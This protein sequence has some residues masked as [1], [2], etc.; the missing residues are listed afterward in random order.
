MGGIDEHFLGHG[1]VLSPAQHKSA[2]GEVE[3]DW[4]GLIEANDNPDDIARWPGN[5][6]TSSRSA[7]SSRCIAVIDSD[8]LFRV[9]AIVRSHNLLIILA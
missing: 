9:S 3:F 6:L 8:A 1:A 5:A 2:P 7:M 4:A